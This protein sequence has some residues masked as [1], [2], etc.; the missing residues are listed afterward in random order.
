MPALTYKP[1]KYQEY[2]IQ[3]VISEKRLG[4]FLD[5]GLGK[6]SIILTAI[7]NLQIFGEIN[8]VLVI[9]PKKVAEDTWIKEKW[10]WKHTQTLNMGIAVGSQAHRLAVVDAMYDITVINRENVK[11]LVDYWGRN[12]PYDMVIV[13]ELTSFKNPISQRFKALKKVL[14]HI[15]RL[16]GLT[17]TP[18]PKGL[19]D[20][21][22]QVYLLDEG[23]RLGKNITYYRQNYF[24]QNTWDQYTWH[25]KEGAKERIME[26]ISDI[27]ISMK[28]EDYI[29]M[30]DTIYNTISV[31]LSKKDRA[32]Y[33]E[34]E[35]KLVMQIGDQIIDVKTA[36]TLSN[37][38][39]QLCNG[40]VYNENGESVHVHDAK[41][42]A[43]AEL[44]ETAGGQPLLVFVS[45]VSDYERIR[46]HF[47]DKE[48]RIMTCKED[49]FLDEWDAGRVDIGLAHPSST[50]FGLNMQ[51]G[52]HI[53]VWF[54]LQWNLELYSQAIARL[55]RQGQ[56]ET[57]IVN[58]L[59]VEDSVDER[60]MASLADK[61]ITQES[62]ISAV[63]ARIAEYEKR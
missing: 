3:R 45:F 18:A 53:I 23:L 60:V 40:A 14:K 41:L 21:W 61:N 30:P 39:L 5:M 54:G 37:K 43:L 58:H 22:A 44:V 28:A 57:V 52:G 2:C 27:C 46:E 47:K 34:L 15:N 25:P 63:K 35:K 51:N 11:W 55:R 7:S 42:E 62:I 26:R 1:Y 50:A 36:A 9:A 48:L 16:V 32:K 56:K 31:K 6:T 29:D 19:I 38:L 59:V 24:Y 4:L 8:K 10:K 20:L 17:G 33:T 13:D 12:W 49:G